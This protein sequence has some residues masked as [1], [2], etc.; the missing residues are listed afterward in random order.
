MVTASFE[1]T[2]DPLSVVVEA[3]LVSP[4]LNVS[5]SLPSPRVTPPLFAMVAAAVKVVV[6][7][8]KA[9]LYAPAPVD[10]PPMDTAPAKET[11]PAEPVS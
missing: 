5:T 1:V 7:P 10:R 2:S 11:A 6:A 8:V 3:V 9:M 4:P